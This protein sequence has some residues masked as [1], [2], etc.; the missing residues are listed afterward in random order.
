M[1]SIQ[2]VAIP[3]DFKY[4]DTFLKGRPQHKRMDP[5]WIR[6]PSMDVAKRAK[7]FAPFDALRGFS[8]AIIAKD[9]LYEPK[10]DLSEE[11]QEDLNSK[12]SVLYEL[13]RNSRIARENSIPVSVTYFVPCTDRNNEA[14]GIRGSYETIS[15]I[16]LKVDAISKDLILMDGQRIRFDAI[17]TISFDSASDTT[18]KE[19]SE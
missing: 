4:L 2:V 3:Q 6:H 7:I 16:C 12:L 19:W 5:F 15:G 13:T 8:A 10:R 9:A 17:N 11:D 18:W 14:Y 1:F